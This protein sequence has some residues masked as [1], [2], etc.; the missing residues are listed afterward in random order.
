LGDPLGLPFHPAR[1]ASILVAGEPAGVLGEVHPK[2]VDRLDLQAR[3][4]VAEV[5]MGILANHARGRTTYR[6]IPRF[7]PIHRDLAFA[8]DERTPVGGMRAALV[9]A[10]G[11]LV[12]SVVLFDLFTGGPLAE[13][14]KS[15]GF[16]VD[17][18]APDRTLTDAEAESAVRAVAERLRAEFGAELRSS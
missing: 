17:L 3:T 1:S 12:D 11:G 2:V 4:T 9:D 5:D 8:V 13:G 15:V 14:Q 16:S 7:P 10:A 6:E 18:R